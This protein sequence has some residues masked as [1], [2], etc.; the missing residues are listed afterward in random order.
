MTLCLKDFP[1]VLVTSF[2][3]LETKWKH[4]VQNKIYTMILFCTQ[5]KILLQTHGAI[6]LRKLD[7]Y[8]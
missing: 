3:I 4:C 5:K 6:A 2:L 1:K 8:F 7:L